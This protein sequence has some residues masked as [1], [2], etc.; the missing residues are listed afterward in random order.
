M[1][2]LHRGAAGLAFAALVAAGLAPA[3]HADTVAA[4]TLVS[5]VA[6]LGN[7]C[8]GA[9]A[10]GSV[11]FALKR[12]GSATNG[13]VWGNTANV[14]VTPTSQ[15]SGMTLGSTSVTTP[16]NWTTLNPA[17]LI[18]AGDASV[19]LTVPANA[20]TGVRTVGVTYTASGQGASVTTT[21]NDA[22]VTFSWNV[23]DC[24]PADTTAPVITKVL[25]P[26]QP[27]GANGWYRTDVGIDW[28][29][30][31]PESAFTA[32]GCADTALTTDGSLT[33][34]CS[35]TSTGGTAGPVSV[36]VK[37]DATP[38]TLE[39]VV[40]GD[41]G[42]N[43]WYT[44]AVTVSWKAGDDTSGVDLATVCGAS[45]LTED[46]AS[47]T[48][49]CT[50]K[51]LA[52]NTATASA[53]VKRDATDPLVVSHV[54]GTLG[55]GGWY[56]S[57]VEV[58]WT[59]SDATSDLASTTGCGATTLDEDSAGTTYTCTATDRAG[60]G[61][62]E[63][64]DLKRD[65]SAPDVSFTRAGLE[66]DNGW[67]R[68]P[69]V[70]DWT[71]SDGFSGLG[72]VVGCADRTVTADGRHTFP[73]TATDAAGNVAQA[74]ALVDLDAT[75]PSIT[76]TATGRTKGTAWFTGD[77]DV[78]WAVVDPTSG[79][80]SS[81]G[82]D[83][84]TLGEDSTG[85]TYTCSATD[86]AGNTDS[87]STTVKR[88][89]TPP[90]LTLTGGPVHQAT[91]NFGDVPAAATCVASDP[92]SGLVGPCA[93][94]AGPTAVG[95][96]AQVATATDKAGNVATDTRSYTVAAWRSDGFYKPVTMG[97]T[98]VNTVK[99][100]STVP[101][102]FNVFK[103]TTAMTSGIGAT[104]VAKKVGCDGS[105]LA[106]AVDEFGTT[107]STS[108]RYDASGAQWVQNWATPSSGKAS[109]YRVTLTTAD[110][111]ST[112]ADFALK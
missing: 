80:T 15:P 60:N 68:G 8:R 6:S 108:L 54:G 42:Q 11:G 90:V 39:P 49:S 36:T 102:K 5:G 65:A 21:S 93:V 41:L 82:C 2:L 58:T 91:Y 77:V 76:P 10:T 81:A 27:D 3:A 12:T 50:V 74:S 94:T 4:D 56:T 98:V 16:F 106:A 20:A 28:T 78:T 107:G 29:V 105:D 40:V 85:T 37:R 96:G 79:V 100:G 110:G 59:V 25:T 32:Q 66:G 69:V 47:R 67:Y 52:G 73:C 7:V 46:V 63:T 19:S 18:D 62:S 30:S 70:L 95:S 89:A 34:S 44:G 23:V 83:K 17:T 9:T 103:G 104:F 61:T 112:S 84:V 13:Q 48:F 45:T 38:P 71:V 22:S 14:T 24:T 1:T 55:G 26:A 111:S 75:A 53:T 101:L 97:A 51:D 72:T 35:A 87:V 64:V 43:G 33:S 92:T 99:A 109:C 31:D 57:D 88:D 86:D